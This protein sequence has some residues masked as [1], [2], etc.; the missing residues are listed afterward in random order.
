MH[1]RKMWLRFRRKI[2]LNRCFRLVS[3]LVIA[4]ALFFS[5]T[6]IPVYATSL[7]PVIGTAGIEAVENA[8]VG[9]ILFDLLSQGIEFSFEVGEWTVDKFLEL[10]GLNDNEEFNAAKQDLISFLDPE[11]ETVIHPVQQDPNR[12]LR[13]K[14][15]FESKADE[16]QI[17]WPIE[18]SE[19]QLEVLAGAYDIRH[20]TL[21]TPSFFTNTSGG[22]TMQ[23]EQ[24]YDR[25]SSI[26]MVSSE[27]FGRS[28]V[29][30]INNDNIK[31]FINLNDY[32]VSLYNSDFSV[33]LSDNT[34]VNYF[35]GPYGYYQSPKWIGV[36][37]IVD[38]EFVL[39]KSL[40][41]RGSYSISNTFSRSQE[42]FWTYTY[43]YGGKLYSLQRN[44]TNA[45]YS[46]W[47]SKNTDIYVGYSVSDRHKLENPYKD[48][49]SYSGQ[50]IASYNYPVPM[51]VAYPE[52]SFI[53]YTEVFEAL[54]SAINNKATF[55]FADID[56]LVVDVNGQKAI[57]TYEVI[58]YDYDVLEDEIFGS[59]RLIVSP[60]PEYMKAYGN[61]L[62]TAGNII[63]NSVAVIPEDISLFLFGGSFVL[64]I[65]LVLRRGSE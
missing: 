19:Y 63:N 47:G 57:S 35:E 40:C 33:N 24:V 20:Q 8:A 2:K 27:T 61:G 4:V 14:Q 38:D 10:T 31:Y 34:Y 6:A 28:S 15:V 12:I 41:D 48:T 42:N 39:H 53:D 18:L 23:S 54:I 9:S 21:Y 37:S 25:L 58:R 1:F 36:E 7:I 13:R 44:L 49:L 30:A 17:L 60:D 62:E 29:W 52:G 26:F 46:L 64:L 56:D 45:L 3:T 65:I 59:N 43:Y 16:S 5:S 32:T 22:Y 55:S 11:T 50:Y 51:Y